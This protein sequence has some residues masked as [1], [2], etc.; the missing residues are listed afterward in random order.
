M[1]APARFTVETFS[2]GRGDLEII[3]LNPDGKVE[4]VIIMH[5]HRIDE[6]VVF[7]YSLNSNLEIIS[8]NHIKSKIK[9][10]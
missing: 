4:Q 2:A 3:V 9:I 10:R 8:C 6:Y 7:I 5:I 1:G